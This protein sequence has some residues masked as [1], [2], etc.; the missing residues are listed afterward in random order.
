[1]C[2]FHLH[3]HTHT[4]THAHAHTH[5][6]THAHMHT[7]THTIQFAVVRV[8]NGYTFKLY[9][10]KVKGEIFTASTKRST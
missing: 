4:H 3:T 5:T 6:H 7:H 8:G 1:M 2:K 10:L 9:K